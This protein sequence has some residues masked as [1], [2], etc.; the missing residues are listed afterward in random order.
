M[1]G[2]TKTAASKTPER[3]RVNVVRPAVIE[4]PMAERAYSVPEFHKFVVSLSHRPF[5]KARGNRRSGRVDVL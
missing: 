4:T 1:I 5:R 2:L 3:I